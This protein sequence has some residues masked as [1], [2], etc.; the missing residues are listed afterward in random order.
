MVLNKANEL[1]S[2]GVDVI[3]FGPGEPDFRTPLPVC[4]AAKL[5]IDHGLTK[6]T[7]ALGTN[8][9]RDTI[10][11]NY[12]RRFSTAVKRENVIVGTGGKQELFN[13]VL[14]MVSD[15]DEVIIPSPYWV[16]FPDQVVFAGGVPVFVSTS[17]ANG[18]RPTADLIS[19]ALTPKSRGVILNSPCN[20][21]GAV[22]ERKELEAIIEL[23]AANDMFLIFDET[24]ELFV[25]DGLKHVSAISW[26]DRYPETI[27]VV[28]SCS[29]TFAMTGWR[30]G[31]SVA[32][33]ELIAAM[34]K[35]QSH[36]TSNPCSISQ[37]AAIAAL[38]GAGDEVEAM[39]AAYVERR[40]WLVP[41]LNAIEGIDC[42]P[43]DGAFY[44]F[45]RISDLFGGQVTDSSSLATFLLDEA[46]VAVVPGAA[47]G[48]DDFIRISYA[49]SMD[50]LREGV[51][52][53]ENAV[54]TLR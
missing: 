36:S 31:Y 15:G 25:Y 20:P 53:I 29:K 30:V 28:N 19:A 52:R 39:Y 13:A 27:V 45:P 4:E 38:K 8:D 34:G 5:A 51:S 12:N 2:K 37:V 1:I 6:Y 14:A 32:H 17:A 49:T 44:V 50:A 22:V 43:P 54:R 10:A 16:S 33:P 3:D 26:L 24:Y 41:A 7:N 42:T 48:A 11:D 18:F 46:R 23:C 47:F 40:A 21:T 9:L 35:I